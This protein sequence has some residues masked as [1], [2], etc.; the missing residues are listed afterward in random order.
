M[1]LVEQDVN[2]LMLL[3]SLC[4]AASGCVKVV[5]SKVL[6]T[7]IRV[8]KTHRPSRD[9]VVRL[10]VTLCDTKVGLHHV[11]ACGGHELA[12][13]VLRM[14]GRDD[15]SATHLVS[16]MAPSEAAIHIAVVNGAVAATNLLSRLSKMEAARRATVEAGGVEALSL[17]RLVYC[18]MKPFAD[19]VD[20]A[21]RS[22]IDGLVVDRDFIAHE[23]VVAE[24]GAR[25]AALVYARAFATAK[26]S[27]PLPTGPVFVCDQCGAAPPRMKTCSNCGDVKCAQPPSRAM[28]IT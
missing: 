9:A 25:A 19:V 14:I 10:M 7:A 4:C 20:D 18:E 15:P 13:D 6:E 23:H 26:S 3:G 2:V 11:F 16:L 24:R 22:L 27:T 21:V 12:I 28:H 1:S 5:E 8:A 17:V